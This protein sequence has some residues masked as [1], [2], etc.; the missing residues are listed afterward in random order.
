MK[1]ILL[2][3]KKTEAQDFGDFGVYP[4]STYAKFSEN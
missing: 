2:K 3:T 4:F 1:H